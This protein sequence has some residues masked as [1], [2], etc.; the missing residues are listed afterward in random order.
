MC[1]RRVNPSV[2]YLSTDTHSSLNEVAGKYVPFL[3]EVTLSV[4]S[5]GKH[6][7]PARF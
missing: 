4:D 3:P 2:P 7:A 1:Y 6:T 5:N